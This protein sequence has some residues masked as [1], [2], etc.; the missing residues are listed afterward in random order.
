MTETRNMTKTQPVRFVDGVPQ[1]RR[2][3]GSAEDGAGR[4][5]VD[6]T[7]TLAPVPVPV[8]PDTAVVAEPVKREATRPNGV[9]SATFT[10][11]R[12]RSRS[13]LRLAVV[14]GVAL[15]ALWMIGVVAAYIALARMGV[16][17]RLNATLA[18]LVKGSGHD[19]GNVASF[20]NV[21]IAGVVLGLL[22]V[23]LVGLLA[24]ACAQVYNSCS[25]I[26]GGVELT[27]AEPRGVTH[28]PQC[29]RRD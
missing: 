25:E 24:A 2:P 8:V 14:V 1:Q 11:V 28:R 4:R 7:A 21:V 26:A 9:R 17:D 22:N 18:D 15:F 5:L 3:E 19:V 20:G 16:W 23:A 27:L 10:I 6:A 13:V 29:T 12:V